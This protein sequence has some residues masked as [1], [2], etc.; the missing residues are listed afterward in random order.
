MSRGRGDTRNGQRPK[1]AD[2]R[3]QGQREGEDIPD[4]LRRAAVDSDAAQLAFER[5]FDRPQ[6]DQP[7]MMLQLG[8][9]DLFRHWS[10][11]MSDEDVTIAVRGTATAAEGI[12]MTA[13][14]AALDPVIA[15]VAV[16]ALLYEQQLVRALWALRNNP[17]LTTPELEAV[18]AAEA[19]GRDTTAAVK[20]YMATVTDRQFGEA[21]LNRVRR[22]RRRRTPSPLERFRSQITRNGGAYE[23]EPAAGSTD[24]LARAERFAGACA[25]IIRALVPDDPPDRPV[26]VFEED[27]H[28]VVEYERRVPRAAA[29]FVESYVQDAL[30]EHGAE[31]LVEVRP[32]ALYT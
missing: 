14:L 26:R 20:E 32:V 19:L 18:L 3:P 7:V 30:A 9:A 10:A 21:V 13:R 4:L 12:D 16:A 25:Q 1:G 8:T 28:V 6:D 17:W 15:E 23:P 31:R 29:Q 24:V 5:G 22:D 27:G 11:A 2:H